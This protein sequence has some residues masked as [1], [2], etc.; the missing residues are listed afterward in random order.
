MSKS[1]QRQY[2]RNHNGEF[3]I[4]EKNDNMSSYTFLVGVHFTRSEHEYWHFT[5]FTVAF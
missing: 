2:D 1:A 4:L 3:V 5:D